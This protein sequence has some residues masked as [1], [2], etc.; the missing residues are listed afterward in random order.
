MGEADVILGIRIKHED[1]GITITQSHYIEKILKKFKYDYCC[2]VSTP[3]D[4]TIK[5]MPN[6]SRVVDQLKY[7]RA[8]GCLMYTMTSTRP[9]IAYAMGKL[10]RYRMVFVPFTG[11]DNHNRSV[12]FG[13]GLLSDETVKSYKWLL[14]SFK[15]AFVADPQVVVTDQDASMKQAV[16]AE[17]PNARHR[18]CMWH[19]M[20]KLVTK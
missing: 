19:I 3:L 6:T 8:I 14:Q 10:S 12:T 2:P 16:E 17:F 13:A 15:K 11:I 7:F 5:L 20:Q 9:Y 1:K 18:L 4:L